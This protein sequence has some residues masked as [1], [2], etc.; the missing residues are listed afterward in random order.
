M[1]ADFVKFGL[2]PELIG[3]VPVV[4]SL[5]E[6]DEEALVRILKEPKNSLLKQYTKLFAMDNVELIVDED[7]LRAFAR[8]TIERKTGARGLR[9]IMEQTVLEPMFT[10]PSDRTVRQCRITRAV[11]EGKEEPILVRETEKE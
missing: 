5:E 2:I 11:V 6:L 9:Q 10:I 8:E 4:V 1:P 3:R 7:A